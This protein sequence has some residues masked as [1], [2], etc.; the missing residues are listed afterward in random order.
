MYHYTESGLRNVWLRNGYTIIDTSYG[1]AVTVQNLNGLIR[2][3][4]TALVQKPH[5][6]TSPEIRYLRHFLDI[7]QK[8][9]AVFVGVQEQTVSLWERSKQRIP[10]S[11]DVV[12]RA[13]VSEALSGKLKFRELLEA[14]SRKN[15][16]IVTERITFETVK[17]SD[18]LIAA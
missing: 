7:S 10:R 12:L 4:A 3:I 1:P 2:A 5:T 16:V 14:I 8:D 18:W 15:D 9:F 6:L 17:Q 13:L 11:A